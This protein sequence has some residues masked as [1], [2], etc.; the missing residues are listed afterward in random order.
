M[1]KCKCAHRIADAIFFR[2]DDI[3]ACAFKLSD[4][5][6]VPGPRDNQ[7]IGS[8]ISC[9]L[10]H[11]HGCVGVRQ[12][13]DDRTGPFESR[14]LEDPPTCRIANDGV[15]PPTLQALN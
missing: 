8:Q 9:L 11:V 4:M 1:V 3:C 12:G 15:Q 2:H 7:N 13:H 6:V 14:V 5:H 10:D